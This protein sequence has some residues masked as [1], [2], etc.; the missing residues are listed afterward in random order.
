MTLNKLKTF[1]CFKIFKEGR[2]LDED[3]QRSSKLSTGITLKNLTQICEIIR[4]GRRQTIRD[5]GEAVDMSYAT[6]EHILS[7]VNMRR[8]IIKLSSDFKCWISGSEECKFALQRTIAEDSNFLSKVITDD[9]NK[10]YDNDLETKRVRSML[11]F[12]ILLV[13]SPMV[14]IRSVI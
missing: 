9:E 6:Y 3:N 1:E 8:I 2:V 11:C 5:V 4:Q 14:F 10:V 12:S 7:V 13:R